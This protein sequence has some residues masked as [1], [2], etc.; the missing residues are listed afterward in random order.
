VNEANWG[1]EIG[2]D[3]PQLALLEKGA[4]IC[5]P[6]PSLSPVKAWES[7]ILLFKDKVFIILFIMLFTCFF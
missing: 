4:T 2:I 1:E 5:C 3:E 6:I 7:L